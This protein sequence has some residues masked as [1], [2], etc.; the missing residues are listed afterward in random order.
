V[1]LSLPVKP[2]MK[3]LSLDVIRSFGGE[4]DNRE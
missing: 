4:K 2:E 1:T 3:D